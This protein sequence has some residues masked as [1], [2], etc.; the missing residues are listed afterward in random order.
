MQLLFKNSNPSGHI[1]K[2]TT[3]WWSTFVRIPHKA[4]CQLNNMEAETKLEAMP[5]YTIEVGHMKSGS[6]IVLILKSLK[7]NSDSL[8]D[9]IGEVKAALLVFKDMGLGQ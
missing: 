5:A 8:P 4:V 1:H 7:V 2:V 9:A 3:I 6:D